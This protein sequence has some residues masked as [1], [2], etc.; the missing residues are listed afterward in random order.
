[1]SVTPREA[2]RTLPVR[3]DDFDFGEPWFRQ[4]LSRGISTSRPR[5]SVISHSSSTTSSGWRDA[6]SHSEAAVRTHPQPT[7]TSGEAQE[8]ARQVLTLKLQTR[9][10]PVRLIASDGTGRT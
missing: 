1:M 9:P 7:D 10:Q 3:A 6:E 2:G 8:G 5:A 4:S